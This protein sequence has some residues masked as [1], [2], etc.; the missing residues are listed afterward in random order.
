[1]C[2]EGKVPMILPKAPPNRSINRATPIAMK[3]ANPDV[4][5]I[6]K[7]SIIQILS[8][9]RSQYSFFQQTTLDIKILRKDKFVNKRIKDPKLINS[10][11]MFGY[12][13]YSFHHHFRL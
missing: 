7:K 12:R 8:T 3:K 11:L 6:L 5:K 10:F 4:R 2:V 9:K 13:H 1:M